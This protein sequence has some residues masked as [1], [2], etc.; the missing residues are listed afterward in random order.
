[1]AEQVGAQITVGAN[2]EV[3]PAAQ[4]ARE[5]AEAKAEAEQGEGGRP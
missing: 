1:M 5:H 2:A 4:V 3:I